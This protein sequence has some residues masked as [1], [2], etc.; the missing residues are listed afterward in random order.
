MSLNKHIGPGLAL[1]QGEL[2]LKDNG[3]VEATFKKF[4]HSSEHLK[5]TKH[6][7]VY[8]TNFR[9]LFV[10]NSKNDMLH[11]LSMPFPKIKDFE[12]KQP[13]FGANYLQ[14]RILAEPDGGWMGSATFE[15]VFKNGGAIEIGQKL[16]E[17]ATNPSQSM[18]TAPATTIIVNPAN[19]VQGYAMPGAENAYCFPAPT[20]PPVY[21]GPPQP[22]MYPNYPAQSPTAP[23]TGDAKAAE[24]EQNSLPPQYSAYSAPP[25]YDDIEKKHQ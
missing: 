5:G 3:G 14:G 1:Y 15:M 17:L 19:T 24:A 10:N 12:I 13:M 21:A 22:P 16:V 20:A 9:L 18:Y 8:L 23:I 4:S 2:V 6:G 11:E 25:K 7:H